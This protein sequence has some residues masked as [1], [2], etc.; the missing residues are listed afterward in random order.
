MAQHTRR[1]FLQKTGQLSVLSLFS[2]SAFHTQSAYAQVLGETAKIM[3]GFPPGG[4]PDIV[5]RR[6]ADAL[7]GKLAT[8]VVVENR[9]GAAG[10]IAVDAAKLAPADGLTLILNP[11]GVLTVNPHT[12]RN[13]GYKPFEDLTPIG[14]T[15][16][17][18]F[19]FA[20]GPAV[21]ESVK[22]I[23]D[24][25]AWAKQ[26]A[27]AGKVSFGSPAA[28]AP[29]HFAGDVLNRALNLG[30]THVPYRGGTPA[31]TDLLAGQIA[32]VSLTL[33]DLVANAKA[34]KLRILAST[35]PTR[36]RFTPTVATF[37]EQG[38]AGLDLRD[39]FG[40]YIAGKASNQVVAKVAPLVA[41]AMSSAEMIQQLSVASLEAKSSTPQELD[42]MARID[43]ERWGPIVKASGFLAD[44]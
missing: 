13:L 1:N 7:R 27:N 42:Q 29:P 25:A 38:V 18:D 3:V 5:A 33:G 4:A 31:I 40:I 23:S 44:N 21:P 10:K 11:A 17:I 43:F 37:A 24:F 20:V 30:M 6:L 15:C 14:L 9:P 28:G 22:N 34:G 26:S 41:S 16:V 36:S 8:T 39:W 12:Y 32:A 35:G 19:G 2:A